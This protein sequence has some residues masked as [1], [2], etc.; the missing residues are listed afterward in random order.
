[1]S[2]HPTHANT[3]IRQGVKVQVRKNG[4]RPNASLRGLIRILPN[5]VKL[6]IVDARNSMDLNAMT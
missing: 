6:G 4:S 2:N 5:V 1:M 3:K